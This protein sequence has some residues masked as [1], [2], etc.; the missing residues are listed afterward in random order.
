[1]NVSNSRRRVDPPLWVALIA[2]ALAM[3]LILGASYLLI[4]H[5]HPSA[6]SIDHPA[7]P[8][9]DSQTMAQVVEPAKE[10]VAVAQ[11]QEATGGYVF[12]SCR[13]LH[14]PPYQGAVYMNFKLPTVTKTDTLVYLREIGDA[15]VANGWTEGLASNQHLFGH[16]VK[17]DGV[18]AIF[19][20]NP[21]QANYG[22][23]QL[24]G[25]CRNTTDH[26]NDSTTWTDV[27]SALR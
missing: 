21:D 2:A 15:L 22:S 13:D 6:G 16:T 7:Q 18:I 19:Y 24:Y 20:Q 9:T 8:L 5:L 27:T 1:M 14:D 4:Q 12:M 25:E 11:L 23:M 10:I 26:A 17:K 3:S